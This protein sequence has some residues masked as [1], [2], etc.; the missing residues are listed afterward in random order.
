MGLDEDRLPI[1]P[2]CALVP[3]P[4]QRAYAEEWLDDDVMVC[5]GSRHCRRSCSCDLAGTTADLPDW[6]TQE[7]TVPGPVRVVYTSAD[8]APGCG[9]GAE[10]AVAV[11]G[12][13]CAVRAARVHAAAQPGRAAARHDAA[14]AANLQGR[15]DRGRDAASPVH[16]AGGHPAGAA[17]PTYSFVRQRGGLSI[18]QA[19]PPL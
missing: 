15:V 4:R 2:A 6:P 8:D 18:T 19:R 12:R 11:R 1:G 17:R 7:G 13:R 3:V 10:E 16:S 5:G 9:D 14:T